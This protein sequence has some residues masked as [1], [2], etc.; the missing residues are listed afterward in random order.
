MATSGNF[1][2]FQLPFGASNKSNP[3]PTPQNPN[4]NFPASQQLD[5]KNN[6]GANAASGGAGNGGNEPNNNP[7]NN[8]DP[9]K[10][11]QGSLL[12]PYKDFFTLP[13]DKDGNT[14]Q[15]TDP[16]AAPI[17]NVDPAKISE[18]VGKMNFGAGMD[19]ELLQKA[20]SG[21]DPAAFMSVLN[22]MVQKGVAAGMTA[23]AGMVSNAIS[24]HSERLDAALPERFRN[25]QLSQTRSTNPV[26]N[27][28]AVV[29]VLEATKKMFAQSNPHLTPAQVAEHA[30]NYVLA[31]RGELNNQDT[32]L[33]NKNRKPA[34][35]EVDWVAN[36]GMDSGQ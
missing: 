33:Q 10:G 23:N 14:V 12:D 24:K 31:V 4:P 22:T 27:H 19:P 5:P 6:T 11:A 26:L 9:N 18:V 25:L 28:P 30:E 21:Q 3:T 35:G 34:A 29:P 32:L 36:F 16:L 1:L 8:P 13:T 2:G 20:M 17:M 15:N 7:N